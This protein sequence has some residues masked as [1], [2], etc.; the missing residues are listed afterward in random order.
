MNWVDVE[1]SSH[2]SLNTWLYSDIA[3]EEYCRYEAFTSHLTVLLLLI[4]V[5]ICMYVASFLLSYR[6][7]SSWYRHLYCS[8]KVLKYYNAMITVPQIVTLDR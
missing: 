1:L 4:Y 5:M 7:S 6:V 8:R 3:S 2:F